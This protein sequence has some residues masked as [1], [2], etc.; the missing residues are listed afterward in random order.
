LRTKSAP[1]SLHA[2]ISLAPNMHD[3][4]AV[5]VVSMRVSRIIN[6]RNPLLL[7]LPWSEQRANKER[8]KSEGR[9]N[10]VRIFSGFY[11]RKDAGIGV[12]GKRVKRTCCRCKFIV[13]ERNAHLYRHAYS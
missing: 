11:V 3:N 5:Y 7:S 8:T 4:Q 12:C 10:K 13:R 1:S 2:C 9:A 6:L